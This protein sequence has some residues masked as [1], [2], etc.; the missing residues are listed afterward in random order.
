MNPNRRRTCSTCNTLKPPAKYNTLRRQCNDCRNEKAKARLARMTP[1]QQEL[2]L[3]T[4]RLNTR[5]WK[6]N[7]RERCNDYNREWKK[8]N[9]ERLREGTRERVRRWRLKRK[10]SQLAHENIE[11]ND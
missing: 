3:A 11:V 8:Q 1:A 2:E 5:D 7:N 9:R 6:A 4:K 10:L